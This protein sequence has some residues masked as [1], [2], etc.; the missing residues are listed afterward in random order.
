[1]TDQAGSRRFGGLAL[2]A[3]TVLAATAIGLATRPVA[4]TP[5]AVPA[6]PA[7]QVGDCVLTRPTGLGWDD[8]PGARAD[9]PP[10]TAEIGPCDGPRYGEIA[11]L[12]AAAASLGEQL[13]QWI[14]CDRQ[15]TEYLGIPPT[16][17]PA[18]ELWRTSVTALATGFLWPSRGQAAAGQR[19]VA[20]V[21][22]I[23]DPFSATIR[24][25]DQVDF[26]LRGG[27]SHP[28]VRDLI[29]MCRQDPLEYVSCAR[30]HRTEVFADADLSSP[31]LTQEQLDQGCRDLVG[32]QTGMPDITA[33]GALTVE[34]TIGAFREQTTDM[35]PVPDLSAARNL[36][37]PADYL[38]AR[39]LVSTTDPARRLTGSLRGLSSAPVPFD[40]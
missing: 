2:V 37:P 32:R 22:A 20:C 10:A 24:R 34:V 25:P 11:R 16:D 33:G 7:P 40:R 19:W 35:E 17:G 26:T 21:A 5:V 30:P 29:G 13:G 36:L 12:D 31:E 8:R 23:S 9:D 1:M 39:C 18:G 6:P 3:L 15:V 4:G 14:D 27:W 28:P 38:Y